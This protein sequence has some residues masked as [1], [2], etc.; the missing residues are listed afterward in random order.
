MSIWAP[1]KKREPYSPNQLLFR[2]S[3]YTLEQS[4]RVLLLLRFEG[5]E[6][7]DTKTLSQKENALEMG[8]YGPVIRGPSSAG[9]RD[10]AGLARLGKKPVLKRNFGFMS[11]LGFSCTILITWEG[12]LMYGSFIPSIANAPQHD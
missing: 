8:T 12:S 2:W 9:S 11:I 1:Q 5:S 10:D 6:I 3:T 7:M 4:R